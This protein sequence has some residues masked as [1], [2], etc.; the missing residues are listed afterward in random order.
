MKKKILIIDDEQLIQKSIANIL[1]GSEYESIH[2]T[3]PL[4]I[5]SII[6][7]HQI[8][9]IFLD[10]W[11]PEKDGLQV[12]KEIKKKWA[13]IPIIIISGHINTNSTI[14][15]TKNGANDFLEKPFSRESLLFKISEHLQ[16]NQ[17]TH[18]S[19]SINYQTIPIKKTPIK[20]K[21]IAKNAVITGK[22]IHKGNNT[23]VILIPLPINSGIIFEEISSG[24]SLKASFENVIST[25][26]ATTLKNKNFS[27]SCVEH[28][29]ATLQV[30]GVCNICIK[31]NE[32]IPILDGSS[33]QWCDLLEKTGIVEQE[34]TLKT[35]EIKKTYE[36]KDPKDNTKWIRI[37]PYD[38][39]KIEYTFSYPNKIQKDQIYKVDLSKEA[40]KV[41]KKEIAP[42]RTFG[43]L[44]ETKTLQAI[45]LA[46][47]ASLDNSL[48]IDK[49]KVVNTNLRFEKEF[50]RHKILDIIGD[51]S[52]SKHP[53][54]CKVTANKTGHKHN[55]ELLRKFFLKI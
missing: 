46:Q 3:N 37:E 40:P 7:P 39:F 48:L 2:C 8:D 24:K 30:Y 6:N 49:A 17:N 44:E 13:H 18:S 31:V 20:Q 5:D 15:V 42:A 34:D 10:I 29:L 35:I 11:M 25:N 22:G 1:K 36:Y 43:F 23:G 19:K 38:G 53:F 14:E 51:F 27:I 41:F 26:Q 54:R 28:L 32:E 45:G 52:L 16:T 12:L 50:A 47:G 21:T 4:K 55:I 33:I 9:L